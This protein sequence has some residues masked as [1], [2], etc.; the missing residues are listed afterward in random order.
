MGQSPAI[1][2]V[3][4]AAKADIELYGVR[5]G[6]DQAVE[7]NRAFKKRIAD[8]RKQEDELEE[9]GRQSDVRQAA[10]NNKARSLRRERNAERDALAKVE[11]DFAKLKSEGWQVGPAKTLSKSGSGRGYRETQ[12]QVAY[13]DQ[14]GI[15]TTQ[16]LSRVVNENNQVL[17][18]GVRVH[19]K[20]AAAA[21]KF[22]D[23]NRY[24]GRNLL[25][26]VKHVT[27]WTAAVGVL[28]GTINLLKRSVGTMAEI[29]H[30]TARL[31]QV[32]RH[33]SDEAKRLADGVIHLA[34]MNGRASNEAMES[35]IQWSRLGYNRIQVMEAVRVS[36]TAANVAEMTAAEATNHLSSLTQVYGLRVSELNS[37]LG[38]LN[39]VSNTYNVTNKEMLTGLTRVSAIAKQAGLGL[40]ELIGLI[41]AGVGATGQSGSMIGNA[42]KAA[43]GSIAS[44]DKQEAL[45]KMFDFEVTVHGGEDLKS[46]SQILAEMFV[47]YQDMTRAERQSMLFTIAGKHQA[48]RL[49]AVLDN[50]VKSQTLAIQAQLN[51]NSAEEENALIVATLRSQYAGLVAEFERFVNLRGNAGAAGGLAEMAKTGKTLLAVMNAFPG[52][53]TVVL[54]LFSAM[55]IRVGISAAAMTAA[56]AKAGV[57]VST[58]RAVKEAVLGLSLPLLKLF[59][60]RGLLNYAT[61]GAVS[62]IKILNGIAYDV[63]GGRGS[64]VR[65]GDATA[66][67]TKNIHFMRGAVALLGATLRTVVLPLLGLYAAMKLFNAAGESLGFTASSSAAKA[68]DAGTREVER[69]TK[70]Y[71]AAAEAAKFYDTTLKLLADSRNEASKQRAL[72]GAVEVGGTLIPGKQGKYEGELKF[73][74]R[75]TDANEKAAARV[76]LVEKLKTDALIYGNEQRTRQYAKEAENIARLSVELE[77]MESSTAVSMGFSKSKVEDLKGQLEEARG[78]QVSRITEDMQNQAESQETWLRNDQ[79][80][81]SYLE[82]HKAEVQAISDLYNQIP[83]IGVAGK[84]EADLQRIIHLRQKDQ[85]ELGVI[86][87]AIERDRSGGVDEE[88]LR[89][90]SDR[91]RKA[92]QDLNDDIARSAGSSKDAKQAYFHLKSLFVNPLLAAAGKPED[93]FIDPNT[94]V[95]MKE[96]VAKLI[97][98]KKAIDAQLASVAKA[99]DS[100]RLKGEKKN[101]EEHIKKLIAE[102]SGLTAALPYKAVQDRRELALSIAR[103]EGESFGFGGNIGEQLTNQRRGLAKS[104]LDHESRAH[105]ARSAKDLVEEENHLVATIKQ[106]EMLDQN[107]VKI[108]ETAL[109]LKKQLHNEEKA[110]QKTLSGKGP[111]DLLR[112][113]AIDRMSRRG[114]TGGAFW[115]IAPESRQAFQELPQNSETARAGRDL[116]RNNPDIINRDGGINLKG[117][118]EAQ[119]VARATISQL[120]G[121]LMDLR[122]FNKPDEAGAGI[123]QQVVSA[124][125]LGFATMGERI[126]PM[127]NESLRAFALRLD[128]IVAGGGGGGHS[129]TPVD[130]GS[131]LPVAVTASPAYGRRMRGGLP[132]IEALAAQIS[133]G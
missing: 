106:T 122:K 77:R 12:E 29:E 9:I 131:A 101:L 69:A 44:P 116:A 33:G 45:R 64:V 24:I 108:A 76:A 8:A 4:T 23:A 17:S 56:G 119:A 35:A 51:L 62:K 43:I 5:G 36:L 10:R 73:I 14:N 112:S 89:E 21:A 38:M 124:V 107:R 46:M 97:E 120:T 15:R 16:T 100:K 67:A 103:A 93:A 87:A 58:F 72:A 133:G 111:G 84:A 19:E 75:I 52:I 79:L 95:G 83:T 32:F 118:Q 22:D 65:L 39:S 113:L 13:K 49:A 50:Y 105:A 60:S 117:L 127:V 53:T 26:N 82:R 70:A 88:L 54:G 1:T 115:A 34:A 63:S 11:S 41:G 104:A 81:L 96:Q 2:K 86:N 99:G 92:I 40:A 132:S 20:A 130:A 110:Y 90:Q 71:E 55:A 109:D 123:S 6:F 98:E 61:D 102:E 30:Q 126:L 68:I 3:G 80:H 91:K 78:K 7:E 59:S 37:V 57:I 74:E 85:A 125:N 128:D 94:L 18:N 48:S 27:A 47:K 129:T 114:I 66:Y 28:Y 42:M 121:W 25:Q 31:T